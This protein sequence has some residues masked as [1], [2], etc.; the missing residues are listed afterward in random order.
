MA[1]G[2]I[3]ETTD[4][5]GGYQAV[6]FLPVKGG[7]GCRRQLAYNSRAAHSRPT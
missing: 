7:L 5:I 3:N 2:P 4:F 6:R 1:A